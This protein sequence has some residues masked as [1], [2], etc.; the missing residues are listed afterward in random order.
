MSSPPRPGLHTQTPDAGE[1]T[2]PSDRLE[3]VRRSYAA[4]QSND[5]RFVEDLLTDDFRFSSPVDVDIDR[6]TYFERC[7][8]DIP[9]P[10]AFEFKRLHEVGDEVVVTYEAENADGR[11]FRNTEVFEFAADRVKRVEVYFGWNL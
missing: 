11:R 3:L 5:R 1:I 7:W 4:Y 10:A 8:T 6:A 9:R 2:V